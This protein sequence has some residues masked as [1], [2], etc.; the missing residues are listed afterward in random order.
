MHPLNCFREIWCADFEFHAPDGH[1]PEPLCLA[2]REVRS[3]RVVTI[4]LTDDPPATPPFAIGPDGLFIAFYA[5]AELGCF[6]ALG[7]PMPERIL[8]LFAEFRAITNGRTMPHGCGLLGVLAHFGLDALAGAEKDDMRALAMRG[9]PHTA[10][11]RA[12]LLCYCQSDAD[13]LA[14]LLPRM[15]PFLDLPR[16][17]LRGRYMAAAASMEWNGVPLDVDALVH[18][19]IYWD[20]IKAKLVREVDRD[21]AVFVPAGRRLDTSTKFGAATIEAAK[22]WNVDADTLAE[23]VEH[24]HKNDVEAMR[25]RLDAIRSARK[26]TGLTGSRIVK[27]IEAGKD[28]ADVPGFDVQARELAGMF[29][30]LGIGT[31]YNPDGVDDDYA[32]RL[33]EVLATTDPVPLPKHH[34]ETIRRAVELVGDGERYI[35]DGPLTFSASRWGEY[36]RKRSIPWPR[37]P[38]GALALDDDTFKEMARQYPAEVGPMRELRHTL[39]QLRLNELA[40]GPDGRN[41]CLLSAF[42]ARTGRNQPSNSRFIFGPSCWHHSLI[43]PEPG[44]G[45]RNSS[46]TPSR[47]TNDSSEK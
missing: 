9:G 36:L 25:D 35:G 33:W 21:Y 17:L 6:L 42:R 20:R 28:Y 46:T 26:V 27:L 14:R 13:A 19:R 32:P 30:D 38:S 41:R 31:G 3:G 12:A 18:L 39:G 16:A 43:K 2:A 23:A 47:S 10:D 44:S 1:R 45:W 22:E 4:W 5:S 7:W 40:V 34:P 8:D 24:V 37:L 29:P 15:L 11:E